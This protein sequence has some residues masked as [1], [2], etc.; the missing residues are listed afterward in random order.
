MR[1]WKR[2]FSESISNSFSW[3]IHAPTRWNDARYANE[4][5][6]SPS[7]LLFCFVK[8]TQRLLSYLVVRIVYTERQFHEMSINSI[9]L[10]DF[11]TYNKKTNSE[12]KMYWFRYGGITKGKTK[13]AKIYWLIS[14]TYSL[15]SAKKPV[16]ML[17]ALQKSP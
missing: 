9:I 8:A 11:D 12:S 14:L 7:L 13:F 3:L 4:T 1:V 16:K 17:L 10:L 15:N 6:F 5:F 2:I